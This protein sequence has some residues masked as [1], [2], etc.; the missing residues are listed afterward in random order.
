MRRNNL[1]FGRIAWL[2]I[3]PRIINTHNH[4]NNGFL[5][6]GR[7]HLLCFGRNAFYGTCIAGMEPHTSDFSRLPHLNIRNLR[8][9]DGQTHLEPLV[10]GDG[11]RRFT[12]FQSPLVGYR[13]SSHFAAD[14]SGQL[15]CIF[16][17]S[18]GRKI[19]KR[20]VRLRIF[21]QQSCVCFLE[22]FRF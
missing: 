11:N 15:L 19:R 21:A 7:H 20:N 10:A 3:I 6:C 1:C 14:W 9:V 13:N 17:L 5:S 12:K 4:F 16:L 18:Y 2:N 22:N 8:F